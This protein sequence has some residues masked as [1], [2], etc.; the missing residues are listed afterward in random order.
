MLVSHFLR[1]RIHSRSGKPFSV[2]CR[3]MAALEA[4]SWP[5]NVRE[6]E[7][8]IERASLLA[9][10]PL[11]RAR[12]LPPV[13]QALATPDDGCEE[14]QVAENVVPSGP[15]PSEA[16][17]PGGAAAAA[18]G[19]RPGAAMPPTL[20][21]LKKYAHE[22]ELAYIQHVLACTGQD[23]EAAAQILE[24]SLATLYRKLSGAGE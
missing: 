18:P 21:S 5:G 22:Q 15:R 7:N 9:D 12:D 19:Q 20:L 24:V 17:T 16:S 11:L 8:A 10:L 3:A 1:E 13:V 4:H 2:S 23:K 6:L 14:Q